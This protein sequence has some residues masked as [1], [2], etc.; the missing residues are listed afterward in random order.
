MTYDEEP[1][2]DPYEPP[3]SPPGARNGTSGTS[4]HPADHDAERAV[5]GAMLLDPDKAIPTVTDILRP[6]DYDQ[7]AHAT[8][9][10]AITYIH[11]TDHTVDPITVAAHLANH[12]GPQRGT[13]LLQGIGGALYLH[14]LTE[15]CT[16]TANADH[17][18]EIVRTAARRRTI[19]NTGTRI[20]Q[21]G[22][23]GALEALDDAF[24]T[25]YTTLDAAAGD[26]GPPPP[27]PTTWSPV[28]LERVLAGDYLDP[29]PTMLRR[30]DQIPLLYAGAVH[31]VSGESESGKT[32]LCLLAALQEIAQGNAVTFIDFEDRPDRVIARL[33]AIGATPDQ[34]RG[35]FCYIRPDRP[36]DDTGR[37]QLTPA[38]VGRTLVILDGVTEAMTLHG[39]DLNSNEDSAKFQALL[40]R[41]IADHG[42][43]VAMI[44]HVPKDKEKQD[45][46]AIG[47]Q[48]KLAGIDGAAY[49][50]KVLAPFARGKRGVAQVIVAKDRP[51]YV[52]E[53]TYGKAIAEFT[54]DGSL[55]DT[56]V[57]AELTPPGG[58]SSAGR[59]WEPT[60]L[61]ERISRYVEANP[62]LTT[63]TLM[64]MVNGKT[65]HKRTALEL[66]ITRG[67]IA[68]THG[69]RGKVTH[70]HTRPYR[71]D[72]DTQED[73]SS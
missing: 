73:T 4:T 56:I 61:M 21:I 67:Y 57:V 32:W 52:R 54:L 22:R 2:F 44:D 27:P 7:P 42:P 29:P 58:Q 53:H 1:P 9:H 11:T 5:L 65:D 48:H 66:L 23:T 33:A 45:R 18:A 28:D 64:S 50:V 72:E 35:H 39:Y 60:H 3:E 62:D 20:A 30:T 6:H 63:T 15:A 68:A 13:T 26:Y 10:N 41:W 51:G 38:L 69:P 59:P 46:H 14:Q 31:T 17:Y 36:L 37:H 25:A 47:A 24:T 49:M 34:I 40:P 43:A 12:P 71:Q 55:D 16:T 19:I 70:H 8:I